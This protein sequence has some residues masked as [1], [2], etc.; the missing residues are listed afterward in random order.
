MMDVIYPPH[1]L[2]QALRKSKI[3]KPE[4]ITNMTTQQKLSDG[5]LVN[6]GLG[7]RVGYKDDLKYVSHTGGT[8]GFSSFM[9][10]SCPEND[11]TVILITNITRRG[12]AFGM[13]RE[14]V[15]NILL[16]KPYEMPGN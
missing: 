12:K 6:Y 8:S 2:K 13:I 4:T 16:R 14:A 15:R 9:K 11:N 7:F 10:F 5:S 3:L 1:R